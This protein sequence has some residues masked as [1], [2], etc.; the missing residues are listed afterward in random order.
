LS[1]SGPDIH[2]HSTLER[3]A[4]DRFSTSWRVPIAA[5]KLLFGKHLRRLGHSQSTLPAAA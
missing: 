4:N 3:H 2:R 1:Q 5:L